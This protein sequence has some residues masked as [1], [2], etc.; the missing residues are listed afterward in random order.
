MVYYRKGQQIAVRIDSGEELISEILK[1]CKSENITSAF[2]QGIGFADEMKVR[3]Y[4]KKDDRFCFKTFSESMELTDIN[5]NIFMAENGIYPHIHVTA[6]DE[7][8]NIK[9]GHLI[10]CSIGATAELLITLAEFDITR[11]ECNDLK[12]GLMQ[13]G[14]ALGLDAAEY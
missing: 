5:G 3:V 14:A 4:N 10:S 8:M 13:F 1:I 2:V 12:L 9:G 11:S 6:A 7:N